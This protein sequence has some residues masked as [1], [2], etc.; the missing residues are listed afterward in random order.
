MAAASLPRPPSAARCTA[1][2]DRLPHPVA[3]ASIAARSPISPPHC[4]AP[5]PRRGRRACRPLPVASAPPGPP[6]S[7]LPAG[8]AR[9]HPPSGECPPT[10]PPRS[11]RPLCS[12][13]AEALP[14]RGPAHAAPGGG[15]GGQAPA[16]LPSSPG[17]ALPGAAA[18]AAAGLAAWPV[19]STAAWRGRRRGPV[20]VG[21]KG[22][23]LWGAMLGVFR[24]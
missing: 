11:P 14:T 5:G 17:I 24:G 8:P 12:C 15:E 2:A 19:S 6:R 7:P 9:A 22:C 13:G 23:G 10:P 3:A 1:P 21:V 16:Q 18:A 4:G 20:G